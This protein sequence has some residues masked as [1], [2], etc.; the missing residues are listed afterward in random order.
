MNYLHV[1][2]HPTFFEGEAKVVTALLHDF[3]IFLHLRKPGA[4]GCEYLSFLKQIPEGLYPKIVLHSSYHLALQY[5]FAGLH[6]S[7]LK[8]GTATSIGGNITKSTSC[9]S[10]KELK[11]LSEKFA[12]C[13]LSPVYDSISKEGYSSN[14]NLQDVQDYLAMEHKTAVVALGGIHQDNIDEIQTLGFDGAAVL[15][16]VWGKNPNRNDDF[17]DR[18]QSL[19]NNID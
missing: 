10:L 18:V 12:F 9:H 1:I 17:A 13:F 14:L 5:E 15:G 16:S 3:D 19:L 11:S 4:S 7:T 6:F 8:R 2:S